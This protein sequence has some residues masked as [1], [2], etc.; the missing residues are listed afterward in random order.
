MPGTYIRDYIDKT[1]V[2]KLTR[3]ETYKYFG[4]PISLD[5]NWKPAQEKLK[6]S[7]KGAMGILYSVKMRKCHRVK[8]M[9]EIYD[10]MMNYFGSCMPIEWDYANELEIIRRNYLRVGLGDPRGSPN[11]LFYD[12]EEGRNIT[13][14]LSVAKAAKHNLIYK[15]L[16]ASQD[17]PAKRA[18]T[19][20]LLTTLKQLGLP[21]GPTLSERLPYKEAYRKLDRKYMMESWLADLTHMG[22]SMHVHPNR[23]GEWNR[24][25]GAVKA[26]RD[27]EGDQWVWLPPNIT[28]DVDLARA[29][30]TH[31]SQLVDSSTLTWMSWEHFSRNN[32]VDRTL[33]EKYQG[34]ITSLGGQGNQST[35]TNATPTLNPSNQPLNHT[36]PHP[37]CAITPHACGG[38]QHVPNQARC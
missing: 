10:G 2:P 25:L 3:H 27:M 29:G 36:N 8:L 9:A 22:V 34:L 38:E 4:V 24:M 30:I 17:T 11:V 35:H 28:Y 18:V 7:L 37:E 21:I 6:K 23:L 12:K 19:S 32:K 1:K 5:L 33:K 31:T 15:V 26:G 13:H 14:A 20:L 16:N